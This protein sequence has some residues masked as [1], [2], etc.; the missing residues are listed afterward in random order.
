VKAQNI[1]LS[2]LLLL[3]IVGRAGVPF[4]TNPRR[5]HALVCNLSSREEQMIRFGLLSDVIFMLCNRSS[6]PEKSGNLTS[7]D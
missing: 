1:I 2:I 6:Q 5:I 4:V 7:N 3:A